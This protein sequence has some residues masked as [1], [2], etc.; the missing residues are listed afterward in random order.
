VT[1]TRT[2]A[3][4]TL[5]ACLAIG[6]GSAAAVPDSDRDLPAKFRTP[7]YSRMSLSVGSPANGRQLRAAKLRPTPHLFIKPDSRD[8]A[9]GHPA[10]V[11]ILK[12]TARQMAREAPG[13][14]LLVGDLSARDGGPLTRHRS[15]QSGRDADVGFFVLDQSGRPKSIEAFVAFDADGKA[16]DGSG[17]QFDDYRNWLMVQMWL[18]DQRAEL[19]YVFVASHLRQRLLAFAR[20]RPAFRKYADGAEKLLLQPHNSGAHDDHF[21]VRIACPE[22]QEGLCYEHG[23]VND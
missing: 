8:A 5:V 15:H 23:W 16:K 21:H 20:A 11:L 19:R 18:K 6:L 22:R 13:A 4:S 7:P 17:L 2:W 14:C 9:Y 10:L 12:R 1:S 3:F